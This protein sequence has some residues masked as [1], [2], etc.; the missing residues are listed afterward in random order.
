MKPV[1][2]AIWLV[3]LLS[4]A[5]SIIVYPSLPE[6]VASHWDAEGQVNGTMSRSL[7]AFLVPGMMVVLA[8]LF[9]AIPSIDP[10]NKNIDTF[11]NAYEGFVLFIM[12]F[13]LAVHA[14]TLLWNLGTKVSP[15]LFVPVAIGLL[16]IYLGY[17]LPKTKRNWFIGI[18]T[19]WTLSSDTVWEKTHKLG[20]KICVAV[21]VLALLGVF[22]SRTWI[23]ILVPVLLFVVITMAYSYFLYVK[24]S[25]SLKQSKYKQARRN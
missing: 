11:R 7:G 5:A 4:I 12:I 25:K 13:L 20:G 8:V 16:F 18:R 21:G 24:E 14:M 23:F 22:F 10:L 9:L 6:S 19:P 1:V 15:N 2:V 17:L 3:V